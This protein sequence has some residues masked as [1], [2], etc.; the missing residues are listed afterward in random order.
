ME[1][2]DRKASHVM[3]HKDGSSHVSAITGVGEKTD[4]YRIIILDGQGLREP[5]TEA[6]VSHLDGSTRMRFV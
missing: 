3:G 5:R 2:L 1:G 4:M 6:H